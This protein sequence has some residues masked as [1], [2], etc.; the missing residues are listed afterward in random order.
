[1]QKKP[2]NELDELLKSATPDTIDKYYE[3]NRAYLAGGPKAFY[4]YMKDT[5]ESKNILLKDMYS[6]AGVGESYGGQILRME[7]HALN[8]DLILSFCIAGHFSVDEANRA[9]KLYGL[10][11]LYSKDMRDS[12]IIVALHRKIFDL[13]EIDDLLEKE[14]HKKLERKIPS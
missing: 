12:C 1:M 2:T 7:K 9:L 4:Y 5:L 13:A 11:P 10:S 3:E 8:R 14:G 6:F